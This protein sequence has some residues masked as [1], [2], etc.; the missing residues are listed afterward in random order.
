MKQFYFLPKPSKFPKKDTIDFILNFS[1]SL[2]IIPS[3]N[4]EAFTF[5]KN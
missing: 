2:E 5:V 3:K 4:L 1:K